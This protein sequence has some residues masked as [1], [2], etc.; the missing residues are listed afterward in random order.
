MHRRICTAFA[1]V[2]GLGGPVA[3]Q[4]TGGGWSEGPSMNFLAQD[5]ASGQPVAPQQPADTL[6]GAVEAPRVAVVELFT[7]QGCSACPPADAFLG[8][9]AE[10]SDVIALA[11][12][13][14]YWDYIGWADGFARAEATKRQKTYARVAGAKMI[15]TP[16]VIVGGQEQ[17]I[18]NDFAAIGEIIRAHLAQV[19][20][21]RLRIRVDGD[22]AVV[23]AVATDPRDATAAASVASLD[24][25]Q[26]AAAPGEIVVQ[27][28]RYKP[29][30][31]VRIDDGENAGRTVSYHNIVT[32]WKTLGRWNGT[33]TLRFRVHVEGV[34]PAA[35][36]F[37]RAGQGPILA[38]ARVQ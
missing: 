25:P 11:L 13:V 29:E 21:L 37:Q 26:G 7:A 36:L 23:E 9:L 33:G 22:T 1:L 15:Y 4:E 8:E 2:I 35:V 3:A 18:G 28:V 6:P 5:H 19:S 31:T 17:L 20:T 27:L 16:Q 32:D 34:E 30:E 10:R 38:A 24:G 12:H 14:D